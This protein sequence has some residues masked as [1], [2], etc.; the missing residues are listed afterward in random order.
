MAGGFESDEF[1][2]LGDEYA[3]KFD[4]ANAIECYKKHFEKN[5]SNYIILNRIGH[6]YGKIDRTAYADTQ[7]KYF[8]KALEI[9]PDYTSAIR[10]LALTYPFIDRYDKALECFNRLFELEPLP[11][12]YFA[13][14]CMK[15]R[16]GDF[17]EGWK[18]YE[19]RF[20]K[21]FGRTEYPKI[22]KPF[23]EG[24]KIPDKT[25]L[26]HFE[27]GF[28]DTIMFC[29]YLQ[30]VKPLVGKIIFRVQNEMVD[31]MKSNIQY[32]IA[33]DKNELKYYLTKNVPDESLSMKNGGDIENINIITDFTKD[34]NTKDI[35]VV[36]TSTPLKELEFDYHIPLVSLMMLLNAKPDNVPLSEG[37][38]QADEQRV[39]K[40]KK[41]FF[42]NDC[43]KIGISWHGMATGNIHRDI[44]LKTFYPLTKL[45]NVKVYSFQ[46]DIR[47]KDR[48]RL[49]SD[50]EFV[51]LGE[52]FKDFSDT[53]AAMANLDLFVTSD[54]VIFN[55][56][57]AM[58]IKTF[59]LL[60]KYCEWRW[61]LD[62]KGT[63]WYKSAEIFRKQNETD[64]WEFLM[65]SIL[66]KL[67]ELK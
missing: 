32:L 50:F 22:D 63:S 65:Q 12:D 57:G 51:D 30:W 48:I 19:S 67:L 16:L 37:Y 29:R 34:F 41:E 20:I 59:V 49:P 15:I 4:F 27:Q 7:I 46:K 52:T 54:N 17:E 23:W 24:Q 43:F 18:Y 56:A 58:G 42:D 39:Q 66:D 35:E 40:Y 47:N 14:A 13:Y 55:L 25:L 9:K 5:P 21:E 64:T 11:D 53:A 44:P 28:G 45:E 31:L 33:E 6:L 38:L 3:Q 62:K 10:N 1:T 8:K 61:F 60:N 36:G 2:K 26:I